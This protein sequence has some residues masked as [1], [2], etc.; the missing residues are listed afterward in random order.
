LRRAFELPWLRFLGRYSYGLYIWHPTAGV[1]LRML[2]FDQRHV[3]ALTHSSTAAVFIALAMK[4]TVALAAAMLSYHLLERPFL[5]FK[6]RMSA[7]RPAFSVPT[8][9]RAKQRLLDVFVAEREIVI[10]RAAALADSK[11]LEDVASDVSGT[12][13]GVSV[14]VEVG[15]RPHP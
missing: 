14:D 5:R 10:P 8:P 6:D 4:M 2:G 7:P 1:P 13:S 12:N 15:Y 9:A 11:P 3:L